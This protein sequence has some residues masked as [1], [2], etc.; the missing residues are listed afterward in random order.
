MRFTSDGFDWPAK[1]LTLQRHKLWSWL[2]D[3]LQREVVVRDGEYRYRFH[4]S[5]LMEF[6]RAAGMMS[7]EPGTV[8]WMN[9]QLQPGETFLDIGANIGIYTIMAGMRVGSEGKVSAFEPH[10]HN[11]GSLVSNIALN[12]L[13]G[14]VTPACLALGARSGMTRFYYKSIEAASSNSSLAGIADTWSSETLTYSA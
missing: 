8:S 6:A 14:V 10:G 3:R 9:E 11:F 13:S 5:T 2:I 7:K 12:G 4:C 1:R